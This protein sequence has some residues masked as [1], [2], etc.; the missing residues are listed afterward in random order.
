MDCYLTESGLD[1]VS[2]LVSRQT[3]GIDGFCHD[4]PLRRHK[5]EQKAD[6]GTFRC[7]ED[8]RKNVGSVCRWAN[9]NPFQGNFMALVLPLCRPERLALVS[10]FNESK[11]WLSV[12]REERVRFL[13][14]LQLTDLF[15]ATRCFSS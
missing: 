14:N 10:Y 5:Y 13:I 15:Y 8:W 12:N 1:E 4:Y 9:Y 3:S 6:E 11:F 7:R 2:H